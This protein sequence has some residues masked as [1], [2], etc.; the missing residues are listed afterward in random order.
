MARHGHQLQAHCIWAHFAIN[1]GIFAALLVIAIA[2][3]LAP[4]N[5]EQ[6]VI[7]GLE[8]MAYMG[9][10]I[11]E[12]GLS[13]LF[14]FFFRIRY[15]TDVKIIFILHEAFIYLGDRERSFE[16]TVFRDS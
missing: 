6:I 4:L 8:A 1:E 7:T 3:F 11:V 12:T 9:N 10:C 15:N 5:Q 13:D 2:H 16:K 14:C